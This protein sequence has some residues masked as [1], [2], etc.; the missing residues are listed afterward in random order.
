MHRTLA[1]DYLTYQQQVQR[2]HGV[3]PSSTVQR[4]K[5]QY[6]TY[7]LYWRYPGVMHNNGQHSDSAKTV[8]LLAVS[9]ARYVVSEQRIHLS[10]CADFRSHLCRLRPKLCGCSVSEPTSPKADCHD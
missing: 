6:L 10:R 2:A 3:S 7:S 9:N 1:A 8:Y 5:P 4:Q